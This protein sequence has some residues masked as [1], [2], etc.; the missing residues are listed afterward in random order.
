MI[1]DPASS[2]AALKATGLAFGGTFLF[3][4]MHTT[5]FHRQAHIKNPNKFFQVM[6][7]LGI[8]LRRDEHLLHH[9]PPFDDDYGVNNGWSNPLARRLQLWKRLD[10]IFYKYTGRMPNNWIQDPSSIPPEVVEA[11]EQDLESIPSDLWDYAETYPARVPPN[12]KA[13]LK[14]AKETWR[15]TF[16]ENRQALYQEIAKKDPKAANEAWTQEQQ[17]FQW[18]YGPKPIPL[19]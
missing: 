1:W 2:L 17:E 15:T 19:N 13:T 3:S 14:T 4:S 5:E 7:S 16:I 10:K 8:T 6:Q 11:L 12:L 18:L 9:K